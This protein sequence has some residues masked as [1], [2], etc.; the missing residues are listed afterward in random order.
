MTPLAIAAGGARHRGKDPIRG[1]AKA[2]VVERELTRASSA[3]SGSAPAEPAAIP[4][5]G[6]PYQAWSDTCA[7]EAFGGVGKVVA[8]SD[9]IATEAT[10]AIRDPMHQS[11]RRASQPEDVLG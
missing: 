1:R 5:P 8:I 4:S 7:D 10:P 3:R 9:R 2:A 6:N 11:L